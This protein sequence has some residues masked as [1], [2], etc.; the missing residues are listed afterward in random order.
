M[1]T[2]LGIGEVARSQYLFSLSNIYNLRNQH[3]P[4]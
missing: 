4:K 2:Q 3:T 1:L